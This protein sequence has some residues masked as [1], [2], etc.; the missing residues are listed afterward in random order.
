MLLRE[1]IIASPLNYTGGKYKLIPQLFPLFPDNVDCFVDLF[2][3]GCNVGINAAANRI[4]CNDNNSKLIGLLQF[5]QNTNI[6]SI[7]QQINNT[8][9][10]FNLSDTERN[11]YAFYN[12]NSADG[13][14][15]YN[16]KSY[17]Q[18]RDSFNSMD[19][20]DPHYYLYLYVLIIFAFNNQIRFNAENKFNLPV[21]KR[22]FNKRMIKKLKSFVDNIENIEF[23]NNSFNE[24]DFS[25]LNENGF[26]Y[27]DPPYLITCATYNEKNNWNYEKEIELL[28]LLDELN[29]Q[30]IKFALSNVLTAKGNVNQILLDWLNLNP[31]YNCHHLDFNYNNSNYHRTK[32]NKEV[33]EVL[34]T[35]YQN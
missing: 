27:A 35:N 29:N 12:C 24:I 23:L 22:D 11:G 14:V 1:N 2:C 20:Q 32:H 28:A 19:E 33:D 4:I 17:L 8:I 16:R 6:D 31:N 18:L 7:L 9:N 30:N 21:G 25:F 3:G 13:L 26:V 15:E 5:F 10:R 34:I